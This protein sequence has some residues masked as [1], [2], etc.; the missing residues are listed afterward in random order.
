MPHNDQAA[1]LADINR[2]IVE[3]RFSPNDWETKFLESVG[4][5]IRFEVE[6]SKSQDEKLEQIWKKVMDD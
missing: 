1:M 2:E 6:L 5:L 3:D 4:E